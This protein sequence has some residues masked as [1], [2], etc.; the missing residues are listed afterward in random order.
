[1]ILFVCGEVIT[2][3]GVDQVLPIRAI[4]LSTSHTS[5]TPGLTSSSRARSDAWS[6]QATSSRPEQSRYVLC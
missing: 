5:M 6:G 2:G 3:R 4:L 1:M